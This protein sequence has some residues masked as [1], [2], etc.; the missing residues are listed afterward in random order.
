MADEGRNPVRLENPDGAG[1]FVIVCDHASNRLPRE[2]GTL[3]LSA[4]AL[5]SHIAWDPGALPVSRALSAMLDAPLLWPDAS[6]LIVDCNRDP[7]APDLIVAESE[8]R[9]VPGN[10]D[11]GEPERVRRLGAVH[12]PYHEA[13]DRCLEGRTGSGRA[14]AVVAVHS[15]T[16]VYLGRSRPWQIG[17]V[18]DDDRRL[19]DPLVDALAADPALNVGVNQPYSPADRVYY[20]LTRHAR[21]RDLPAVMIEIRNDVI[22][23]AAGQ[24]AWADR[25]G[26]ILAS[27]SP[28]VR[29]GADAAA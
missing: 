18:F 6:R 20:T 15:F 5:L 27:L 9:A 22:A 10:L 13:I 29:G 14:T 25:L 4:D 12:V 11:V 8:G 7:G 19:S 1:P 23:D 17:I 2:Y 21:S 26:A 16:P 24:R 3:G 28:V